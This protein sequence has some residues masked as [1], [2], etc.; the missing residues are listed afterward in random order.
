MRS[1]LLTVNC[2]TDRLR[3]ILNNDN[4]VRVAQLD[5]CIDI[6]RTSAQVDRNYSFCSVTQKWGNCVDIHQFI[7][8]HIRQ[9]RS[10]T[11][12]NNCSN[13]SNKGVATGD[14][15]ITGSIP[16]AHNARNKASVPEFTATVCAA[17]AIRHP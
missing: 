17:A 10:G 6:Q 16:N 4:R 12:R 11:G 3:A 8:T 14:H 9:D 1:D 7:V 5:D 13:R 15:L 2:G